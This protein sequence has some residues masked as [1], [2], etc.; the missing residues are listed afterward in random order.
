[1]LF[2]FCLY[3]FLKNQRYFE[4][5]WILAFLERGLSFA[6]IGALIGF[7]EL[8]IAALEMPTGAIA[9]VV[10]RRWSMIWSHVAYIVAFI[11]FGLTISVP[12]LFVGMFAFAVGEAF[13][14]GTHKA[15]IFAWLIQE[16]REKEKTHIYGITR[17]WSKIGSAVSVVIAGVFVFLFQ[18]YSL[19]FWLSG[20]PAAVNIINFW[21]YPQDTR[22]ASHVGSSS[23]IL[24][25]LRDGLQRCLT[26]SSLRTPISESMGFEGMFHASKDYLQPITHQMILSL[27]VLLMLADAQRTS[28]LVATVYVVLYLLSS[29]AARHAGSVVGWFGDPAIASR[30]LW[31]AFTSSFL[32]LLA[33]TITGLTALSI[34][35]FVFLSMLQNLWRPILIGRIADQ[36][37]ES[38]LATIL[39]V[40]SQAKSLGVAVLAPLLG[41]LV[42]YSPDAYRFLPVSVA[43]L[44]IGGLALAAQS[45]RV[46]ENQQVDALLTEEQSI[47]ERLG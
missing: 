25:L 42:D 23:G 15:I 3:G 12:A 17:S 35:S 20:I 38:S 29:I 16:G 10:G 41:V 11:T 47:G 4:S 8:S 46:R 45:F 28:L 31:V 7:R 36:T 9:D 21:G 32:I 34:G 1:L 40:E 44:T 22:S 27:P 33:G 19:I 26:N 5:F 14:T 6:L 37:S 43:G 18:D 30:W 13:R 39:S 24:A 2:R